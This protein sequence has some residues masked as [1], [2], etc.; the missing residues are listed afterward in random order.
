M[1]K[2]LYYKKAIEILTAEA[3]KLLNKSKNLEETFEDGYRL[4]EAVAILSESN[5]PEGYL[6]LNDPDNYEFIIE[7]K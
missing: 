6:G 3:D 7:E 2:E 5:A 4:M 1:E